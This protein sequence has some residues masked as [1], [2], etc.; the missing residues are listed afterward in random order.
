MPASFSV[1][2][3][4]HWRVRAEEAQTLA[5]EMSD[6]VSRAMMLQIAEGY[7]RLAKHAE[8]RAKKLMNVT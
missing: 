4:A 6:K 5:D 2:D 7:E 1:D 8:E 3:P